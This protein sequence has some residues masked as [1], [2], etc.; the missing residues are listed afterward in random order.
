LKL[1]LSMKLQELNEQELKATNGGL[2]GL[3]N[4][5]LISGVALGDLLS[6]TVVGTDD[7]IDADLDVNLNGWTGGLGGG[8][9]LGGV[10]GGLLG[11]IKL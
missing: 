11:G 5:P 9:L 2:L 4:G 3:F 6:L 8:N 1:T 7:K 10:L